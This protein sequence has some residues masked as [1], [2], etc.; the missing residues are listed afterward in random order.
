MNIARASIDMPIITWLIMLGCLFGGIWGFNA[1]GRL[2]DPAFTIKSAVVT[3]LYPG[4]SAE[5]V[6]TEVSEVL[7]SEIQQ[8]AEIDEITSRN[9]PGFS[10]ITVDIQDTYGG[11]ELPDIWQKLRSKVSDAALSLPEG[12][13]TPEVN[14]SFGDVYGLFYAVTAPGYSDREIHRLAR[15]LR[16][17]IL[18]V[19]GVADVSLDGLPSEHIFV[20]PNLA[21]MVNQNIPPSAFVDSISTADSITPAG[22][23]T[24]VTQ[25]VRIDAPEG[26]D[27]VEEIAGLSVGV[28]GEVV[29]LR[30]VSTVLRGRTETPTILIRYNGGEAFTLGVAGLQSDNIVEIGNRVDARLAEIMETIPFGIELNPI[31]QQHLVV[32]ESANGFLVNLATSVT[33]V[34]AVL[35]V[36]MGWRSAI[37]VGA[38]LILT[39]VGSLFFMAIF[40]I[41]MERISLGALIIAMGMLVDNAIVVAESMQIS[42]LRGKSSRDAAEEAGSKSQIPLLGATVIGVMAFAGI[43]LSPDSTGEFMFSLFAVIGISLMLSWVL[44]ITV[45]PLL[46]HY[47]F[48]RG[49]EG[50][51]DPY[52]GFIY[53]AYGALLRGA[54]RVWWLVIPAL[55]ATTVVCYIGFGQ[56]RQQFFPD[57]NTPLFMVH[58]KLPQGTDIHTTADQMELV[59]D[60][61]LAREEVVSVST[62]IGQGA[63]RFLLTYSAE[64]PN[65]SY[66]HMLIRTETLD[67]IPALR[68]DLDAFGIGA[69][70]DGEFRTERLV[71]GP[72]GGAPVEARFSGPDPVVLR[73]LANQA[74][75]RMADASDNALHLRTDWRELE[76]VVAPV[77]STDRAQTAGI[78]RDD[79]ANTLAFATDGI[80]AGVYREDDRLIPI[81]VRLPRESGLSL[82][83]QVVYSDSA[84]AYVPIEQVVDEFEVTVED[85]LIHRLDR[86]STIT[87]AADRP[88]SMTAAEL[89]AEVRATIEEMPLPPGY[90]MEWGGEFE[91]SG[92]ANESLGQQLPVSALVMVLISILLFNA[93]RQPIIIWLLVPMS[94]NGVSL[95]LLG[96]GLPFTFTALL[97]LLSLSG[98]LIKNGIVLVDEIDQVRTEGNPLRDSIVTA[99]VSRLRPVI[100][101]AATTILGMIPLLSDAF[102]VSMAITIMGGLAFASILTLVAAPVFYYV[103]F[104]PGERRASAA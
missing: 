13:Q 66:A 5:E 81:T 90:T 12:V 49:S 102:F 21:Q 92:D 87:V 19:D 56:V 104:A 95:G 65:S 97:G 82:R 4:A 22:A 46:G 100:L 7:E 67:E 58:F 79:V 29:N 94:V 99:S 98:M 93:I 33:I 77:Y 31:Y 84:A 51:A 78:S 69:F 83:D 34:V 36:F 32:D 48:Q 6:A 80:S 1:L 10:L 15:Y 68:A 42:M 40:S 63:T 54:I 71:F 38:T 39:V 9:Q 88:A 70:P 101:A 35:A 96:T 60:W 25:R 26:S 57:S 24:S 18:A 28:S 103:F 20:E 45:T 8:M 73:E 2:E 3:T 76:L 14:D 86:V 44:A 53:R 52:G 43:G 74:L 27:T 41:E 47:F 72:G 75:A 50:S 37:V 30:D 16:R 17:E 59:E 89:H 11:D 55:I 64:D 62:F 85:T 61:L 23:V 91:S